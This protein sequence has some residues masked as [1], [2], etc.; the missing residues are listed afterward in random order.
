MIYSL[1]DG[2]ADQA[3]CRPNDVIIKVNDN[4]VLGKKHKDVVDMMKNSNL[5]KLVVRSGI[6]QVN[7]ATTD[8]QPTGQHHRLHYN[9][10]TS[11]QSRIITGPQPLKDVFKQ[12]YD[13]T[14]VTYLKDILKKTIEQLEKAK[15]QKDKKQI[16]AA[17]KHIKALEEKLEHLESQQTKQRNRHA[18][19]SAEN[20]SF[21]DDDSESTNSQTKKSHSFGQYDQT[22]R[23]TIMAMDSDDENDLTNNNNCS[24]HLMIH[25]NAIT[26]PIPNY[27]GE[28]PEYSIRMTKWLLSQV[29]CNFKYSISGSQNFRVTKF[30]NHKF[31]GS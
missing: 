17:T 19:M 22:N 21:N 3:N 8:H 10:S 15:L 12:A 26:I 2:P 7:C 4:N 31:S 14:N 6:R 9:H 16:E 1:S 20:L 30:Q 29:N 11:S 23:A 24:H 27:I 28:I 5:I 25:Q 13:A 18:S